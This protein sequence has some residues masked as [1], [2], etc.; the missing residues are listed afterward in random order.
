MS[1]K[2]IGSID[3][4]EAI[5]AAWFSIRDNFGELY[6]R[7]TTDDQRHNLVAD[8]DGARD[9]FYVALNGKFQEEDAFVA[10]TKK[11]LSDARAGLEAELKSLKN[12]K[13]ALD[14]VS[15]VVKLMAALAAMGVA[16]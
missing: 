9:A 5:K 14:L 11:Q 1:D 4:F 2:T 3:S 7:A 6:M 10:K 13:H 15:S 16:A 8:R 12:V